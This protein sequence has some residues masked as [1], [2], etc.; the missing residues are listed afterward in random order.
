MN[1]NSLSLPLRLVG[2]DMVWSVAVAR[3]GPESEASWMLDE[4]EMAMVDLEKVPP[5]S[6]GE[7]Q[8]EGIKG[9]PGTELFHRGPGDLAA[10]EARSSSY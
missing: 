1:S 7:E 2:F 3:A 5:G 8:D 6:G 10:A 9:S 4:W